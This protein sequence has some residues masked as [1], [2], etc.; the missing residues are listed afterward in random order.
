MPEMRMDDFLFSPS[1]YSMNGIMKEDM[2]KKLD[3]SENLESPG[4]GRDPSFVTIHV[5][6]QVQIDSSQSHLSLFQKSIQ[7]SCSYA[8][9]ETNS[10]SASIQLICQV[11]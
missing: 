4:K 6:P 10:L 5:T 2:V 9:F 3:S 11:Y 8:S 1:G 7:P